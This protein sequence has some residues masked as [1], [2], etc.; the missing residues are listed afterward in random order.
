M[1]SGP[2]LPDDVANRMSLFYANPTPMLNTL[3]TAS[4]ELV[5]VVSI[6]IRVIGTS[7]FKS[8][9]VS[10][11]PQVTLENTTESLS[12]MASICRVLNENP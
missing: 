10:Q 6:G 1:S 9:L 12:T 7:K 3:A 5:A 2:E 8:A 11:N 4:S